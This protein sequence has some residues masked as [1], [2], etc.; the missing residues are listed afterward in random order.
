MFLAFDAIRAKRRLG[1]ESLRSLSLTLVPLPTESMNA[2]NNQLPCHLATLHSE[3]LAVVTI[4]FG[5][6]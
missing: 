2:A 4:A 6:L 3:R 5:L 1:K